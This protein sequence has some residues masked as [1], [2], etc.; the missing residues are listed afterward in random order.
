MTGV[1][2]TR[3]KDKGVPGREQHAQRTAGFLGDLG[4]GGVQADRASRKHFVKA[5]NDKPQSSD[6]RLYVHYLIQTIRQ[7]YE[8]AFAI[9]I[10]LR[11][12]LGCK[13]L[14]SFLRSQSISRA[15]F[16]QD[17][18]TLKPML[19]ISMLFPPGWKRPFLEAS[20]ITEKN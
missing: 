12:K 11:R 3:R 8:V 13:D 1:H 2:Q 4:R 6:F 7:L 20:R 17:H 16:E 10:V 9:S 15:G 19:L 18:L 14:Q 5:S